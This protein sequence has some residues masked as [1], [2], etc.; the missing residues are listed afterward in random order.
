MHTLKEGKS[1]IIS[2]NEKHT[3]NT[4]IENSKTT[5]IT[6]RILVWQVFYR[7]QYYIIKDID[8]DW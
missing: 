8:L 5:H 3:G 2:K 1:S 7:I 6:G 4:G